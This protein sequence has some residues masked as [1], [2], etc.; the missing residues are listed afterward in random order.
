MWVKICGTTNLEDA[1]MAVD[2]GADAVLLAS[3]T[4]AT[5][6]RDGVIA[7]SGNSCFPSF[8]RLHYSLLP[9]LSELAGVGSRDAVLSRLRDN[10]G[11]SSAT[12]RVPV[13]YAEDVPGQRAT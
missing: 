1:Q 11:D 5:G 3:V 8:A 7:A 6:L 2:A 10:R 12:R 4:R 13:R 9:R